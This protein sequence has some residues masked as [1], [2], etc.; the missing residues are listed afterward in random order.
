MSSFLLYIFSFL[1]RIFLLIYF[2]MLRRIKDKMAAILKI[3]R[4]CKTQVKEPKFKL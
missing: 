3:I 2:L 1:L 4:E